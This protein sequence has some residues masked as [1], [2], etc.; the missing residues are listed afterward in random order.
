MLIIVVLGVCVFIFQSKSEWMEEDGRYTKKELAN[1]V[2]EKEIATVK[3]DLK[4]AQTKNAA[5]EVVVQF[6]YQ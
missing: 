1:E 5:L 4:I 6:S 3:N 2:L